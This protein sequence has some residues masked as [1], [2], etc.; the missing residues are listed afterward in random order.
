MGNVIQLF[1]TASSP[2]MLL[3][4][5]ALDW[6][7]ETADPFRSWYATAILLQVLRSNERC[8]EMALNLQFVE[9]PDEQPESL[10]QSFASAV[11]KATRENAEPRVIIGLLSFLSVW[12]HDSPASVMQFLDESA[13]IQFVHLVHCNAK[14]R[15]SSWM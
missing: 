1:T 2:G 7:V 8:K 14:A 15:F 10:L 9:D 4:H 11:V 12:L 6:A 3:V 5:A 13:N